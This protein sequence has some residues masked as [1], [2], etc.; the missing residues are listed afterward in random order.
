MNL[1]RFLLSHGGLPWTHSPRPGEGKRWGVGI[2]LSP[3]NTF[4]VLYPSPS[5]D[6]ISAVQISPP[7]IDPYPLVHSLLPSFNP[8]IIDEID[9]FFSNA[10]L[11]TCLLDNVAWKMLQSPSG[12]ILHCR[13]MATTPACGWPLQKVAHG[14]RMHVKQRGKIPAQL[15]ACNKSLVLT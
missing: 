5:L 4:Q 1:T 13:Q 8:A 15:P 12:C 2:L 14:G 9:F 10:H 11:A 3:H 6:E 7:F